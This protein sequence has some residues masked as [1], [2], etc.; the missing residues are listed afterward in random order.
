M[1]FFQSPF[2][3]QGLIEFFF[4]VDHEGLRFECPLVYRGDFS[5]QPFDF[6]AKPSFSSSTAF[7]SF[8]K[9]EMASFSSTICLSF[10]E[11]VF[12]MP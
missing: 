6:E 5:T 10:S 4:L 7:L 1:F 3:F 8:S 11:R 12:S 9:F 2:L